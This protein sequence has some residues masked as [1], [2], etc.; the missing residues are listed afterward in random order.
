MGG[1][2]QRALS[3]GEQGPFIEG[4]AL[5]LSALFEDDAYSVVLSVKSNS[6]P[7]DIAFAGSGLML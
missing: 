5:H 2:L 3:D 6:L 1:Y 7:L 4:P